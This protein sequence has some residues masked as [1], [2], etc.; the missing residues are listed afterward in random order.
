MHGFPFHLEHMSTDF[1]MAAYK[2]DGQLSHM[3]CIRK[4]SQNFPLASQWLSPLIFMHNYLH[5]KK[6][7]LLSSFSFIAPLTYQLAK[8]NR[9]WLLKSTF[10]YFSLDPYIDYKSL[11]YNT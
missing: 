3:N 9:I 5:A 4:K 6:K 8:I 7:Q 1:H 11:K 10:L 2:Q